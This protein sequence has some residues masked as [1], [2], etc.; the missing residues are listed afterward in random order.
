MRTIVTIS[1]PPARRPAGLSVTT[2]A[3]S[4]AGATFFLTCAD[5]SAGATFFFV[6]AIDGDD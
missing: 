1:A 4:S 2:C 5:S 6:T 3:D